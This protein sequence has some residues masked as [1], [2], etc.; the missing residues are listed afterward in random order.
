MK[1]SNTKDV[2]VIGAGPA[3]S[4]TASLLAEHGLDVL[5]LDKSEFPRDKTCGDALSPRALKVLERLGLREPVENAGN[6]ISDMLVSGPDGSSTT[7]PVPPQ[8]GFPN[9]SVVIKRRMLDQLLQEQAVRS[10]AQFQ[11]GFHVIRVERTAN[12]AI[13]HG[14]N[15]S[16]RHHLQTRAVVLAVGA[17]M[18]LLRSLDLLPTKPDVSLAA[19]GYY[20][21]I[22]DLDQKLQFRFDGI[23]L[24]GY[25]WVFPV[26]DHQANIGAGYS[27]NSIY[28]FN[29]PTEAVRSFITNTPI[30]GGLH[31]ARLIEPIKG[32]P[33][34][35]DFHRSPTH[36]GRLVL[37]GE[38]AGL[39]NPF[40]GEGIDYAL[41]SAELAAAALASAFD[42]NL[43]FISRLA[44]YDRALRQR[45]Q[46]TF[47]LTH[48]LRRLYMRPATIDPLIRACQRWPDLGQQLIRIMLAYESPRQALS[49]A[50][51]VR[52][53]WAT[54][55]PAATA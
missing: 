40:T 30:K 28:T 2:I 43:N 21:G 5:L 39:V 19:R 55:A 15:A 32:F 53:L 45:F 49:P 31:T 54:L 38:A 8:P 42:E 7:I 13:I 9:Y 51:M 35:T 52:V 29:S 34:R 6:K 46:E 12:A 26:T 11:G 24:P 50:F 27:T 3:G 17:N 44:A 4:T 23:P 37:V 47:T 18:A 16:H 41:E 14:G 48:W 1:S 33:L 22:Q 36:R 20:D 10:G 25:G